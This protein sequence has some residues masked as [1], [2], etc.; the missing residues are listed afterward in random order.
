ME[1]IFVLKVKRGSYSR[2]QAF[3]IHK[4]IKSIL[5]VDDILIMVFDDDDF[6]QVSG[7]DIIINLDDKDYTVNEIRELIVLKNDKG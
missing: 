6:Y 7:E 5:P 3:E 2:E 1:N 4:R